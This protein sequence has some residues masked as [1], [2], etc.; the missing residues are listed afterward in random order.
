MNPL[1]E[2]QI[3][4]YLPEHLRSNTDL[5]SFITS[6]ERSYET[7]DEQ[8]KLLQRSI[9][10]S[11][12]ELY[13]T[14]KKLNKESE[15]QREII[16]KLNEVI[17]NLKGYESKETKK[18]K[19]FDSVKLIEFIGEQTKEILEINKQKD[20]LLSS[21]EKQNTELNEYAQMI[22]HDLQSPLQSIDA[23]T[24]WLKEDYSNK[25][26]TNGLNIIDLIRGSVEKMDILLK[27]I[28]K[29]TNIDK[30]ENKKKDIDLDILIN[31]ILS[32]IENPNNIQ[33]RIH[34]KLPS[35]YADSYRLKLLFFHLLENG[36]KYNDKKT[37][38]FVEINCEDKDQY[39]QF[40]IKDNGKGIDNKYL[41][42]IFDAFQKLENNEKSTGIGLSF[43][44][45][46]VEFYEGEIN[47]KSNLG[48]GTE[49]IFS[50]KK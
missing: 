21:L 41:K 11:S 37:K 15:A 3:R 34:S 22:S 46:I 48:K 43:V 50:L 29:Y 36:I 1:L 7:N 33:I 26:D 2:R 20:V 24:S 39:W 4:K 16:V 13:E 9:T 14:N 32:S 5:I 38:G 6:I 30:I 35:I 17:N 45:K 10:I 8:Y 18:I 25:F 28:I 23:L 49:I 42:I 19:D 27:T 40:F 44:K 12:E 31:D 47:I